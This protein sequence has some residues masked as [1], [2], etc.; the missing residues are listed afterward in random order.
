MPCIVSDPWF[1]K[2]L[3]KVL[4][5]QL[6]VIV[7]TRR[8]GHACEYSGENIFLLTYILSRMPWKSLTGSYSVYPQPRDFRACSDYIP[9]TMHPTLAW[10]IT[11]Y[12]SLLSNATGGNL[13]HLHSVLM[14]QWKLQCWQ[15]IQ[16]RLATVNDRIDQAAVMGQNQHTGR[17]K[18]DNV[19]E[20]AYK[21]EHTDKCSN[22]TVGDTS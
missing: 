16:E 19:C 17:I 15:W 12:T 3:R 21:L 14:L 22:D 8:Q 5:L 7:C 11:L 6:T 1:Y 2:P 4:F 20:S 13:L 9:S 10:S 18:W